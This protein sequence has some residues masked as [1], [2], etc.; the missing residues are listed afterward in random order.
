[1][2]PPRLDPAYLDPAYL[3]PPYLETAY[4]ETAY[5]SRLAKHYQSGAV[6]VGAQFIGRTSGVPPVDG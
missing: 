6:S 2:G 5:L 4:L 1:M 3:D